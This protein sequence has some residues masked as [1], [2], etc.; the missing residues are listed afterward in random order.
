MKTS[1]SSSLKGLTWNLSILNLSLSTTRFSVSSSGKG[2]TEIIN[3]YILQL[4]PSH[5][6]HLLLLVEQ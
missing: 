5:L 1:S 3:K 2:N 6:S 4:S